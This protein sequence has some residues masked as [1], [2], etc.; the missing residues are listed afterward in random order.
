[1]STARQDMLKDLL[2]NVTSSPAMNKLIASL[3]HQPLNISPKD[4]MER[5]Q[6]NASRWDSYVN[7][8]QLNQAL[9]LDL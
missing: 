1:M 6:N 2:H 8:L 5:I 7:R 4:M 9:N 3:L